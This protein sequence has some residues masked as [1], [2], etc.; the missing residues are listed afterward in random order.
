MNPSLLILIEAGF[1]IGAAHAG[2]SIAGTVINTADFILDAARAIDD[3]HQEETGQPLDWNKIR[4][5]ELLPPAG[6]APAEEAAESVEAK[7]TLP[8]E[9]PDGSPD[10]GPSDAE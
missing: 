7:T 8:L 9:T 5:H 10:E 3:L 4:F 2:S 1:K 6:S